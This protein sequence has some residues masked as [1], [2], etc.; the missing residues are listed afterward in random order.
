MTAAPNVEI[1]PPGELDGEWLRAAPP[2]ARPRW[3][4]RRLLGAMLGALLVSG[5]LAYGDAQRESSE[6]FA[7]FAQEQT[8]LARAVAAMISPRPGH[9]AAID[10]DQLLRALASIERPNELAMFLHRRGDPTLRA[11]GGRAF[12][13][14][15]LVEALSHGDS[16]VRLSPVEAEALGLPR[17]TALAGLTRV[18]A[19]HP[20]AWDIVS[21]A[22]AGRQR[23][24]EMW[25]DRR[26]VFSMLVAA[27]LVLTFG[28]AAMRMQRKELLLEHELTVAAVSRQRDERLQ[29]ASRAAVIGTFAIGVAHEISTP[30]GVIAGRAENIEKRLSAPGGASDHNV[31]VIL[32]QIDDIK[33]IIR[34]FLGLARGDAPTAQVIRTETIA[35]AAVTMV[36]HRFSQ[37]GVSLTCDVAPD[38]P[39]VLGDVNLLQHAVTTLLLNAR[40]ASGPGGSVR[41]SV[42]R[43]GDD[44]VIAVDDSGP[45]ISPADAQR[46]VQPFFA[47][48]L[49][50]DGTGLGLAVAHEIVANHGGTLALSSASSHGTRATVRLPATA[51]PA[52]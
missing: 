52:A 37:G 8:T 28:G 39:P 5:L 51:A 7:D 46:A 38:L 41:V 19:G 43:D 31:R 24:R 12:Q 29:Q 45:G 48:K 25:A 9:D 10:E 47:T 18:D 36:E 32:A 3:P 23:D 20:G 27:G 34:G 11:A 26:L 40:D 16:V 17:R 13:G 42:A 44:V 2:A 21:V 49:R 6:A 4:P 1:A 22:S 33:Q 30:L 15:R 35:R 50:K 14:R